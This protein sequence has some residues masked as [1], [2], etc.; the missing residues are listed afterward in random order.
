VPGEETET[1]R[2]APHAPSPT[3]VRPKPPIYNFEAPA[4]LVAA[5]AGQQRWKIHCLGE[6]RVFRQDGTPVQW[7]RIQGATLKTKTLFAYL[8]HRGQ[9]GAAVEEIAD[10]LWPEA[11]STEPSL[12]RLYHTVHCLRMA[13][14]PELTS[15]LIHEELGHTMTTHS[16]YP[17]LFSPLSTNNL[18]LLNRLVVPAM[19]TRLPGEDG[20]VNQDTIDRYVRF[21]KGEVGLIIV[22][23]TAIHTAK[24][25]QL[26]RLG[27]DEFIPGH[28]DLVKQVHDA[29]PSKV[30]L[31]IIHFLKIARSGWRQTVE[32]LSKDEIKA[33][34]RGYGEAAARTREAG[35]DAVELHMAHSYTM[36]SFMSARNKRSDEYGGRSLETRM[37]LMS[38]VM[39]EARRM[40]GPDYP[41]GVRFDGEECIKDGYSIGD[42]KYFALRMAQ[43]SMDY[44]SISAGGK[45]EDAVKREGHPLDPY[46]GYSGDRTMPPLTYPLNVNVYLADAI[47]AFINAHG[48]NTPVITAGRITNAGQAEELLKGGKADLIGMA[49][50]ILADA[51]L[52][53]K[54]REGREDQI[55]YCIYGNICK[56]LEENYKKV[57][58]GSLWPKEYLHAPESADAAP[59]H[60]PN[61]GKLQLELRENGRLRVDWEAAADNEGMYGYEVFRSVNDGPYA[62][63]TSSR[64]TAHVDEQA[65]AGN[66]Y[67]YFVRPYD[68]A[69]NRGPQSNVAEVVVNPDFGLPDGVSIALDG[70]V[71]ANS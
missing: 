64:S 71:I 57:R 18:I 70:K 62:H 8:L 17:L 52:P 49:R 37:R 55:V 13:L 27:A 25:G 69:G 60:W 65:L 15:H 20:F 3:N 32:M 48:F 67:S 36:S 58:C 7:N 44:I 56:Q 14:S 22:E 16:R 46:T 30:A 10:L 19:V 1:S 31:Q 5:H 29:G 41:I 47:K 23:A 51:D 53:K 61:G 42:S 34:V 11:S 24:S 35:Y 6:L 9:K 50:A 21:S 39:V 26:L 2:A 66:K 63:L 38:E 12:N 45:F 4:P 59:P 43:L 54:S 40:C 28:R 33:I 68:L